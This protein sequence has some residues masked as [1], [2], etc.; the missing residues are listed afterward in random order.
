MSISSIGFGKN[1]PAWSTVLSTEDASLTVGIGPSELAQAARLWLT[2]FVGQEVS[3]GL[4][5]PKKEAT[6]DATE[7]KEAVG[8][9][10]PARRGKFPK[11]VAM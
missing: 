3:G 6:F 9:A 4:E 7:K 1:R 11:A 8:F 2:N 10:I 5:K